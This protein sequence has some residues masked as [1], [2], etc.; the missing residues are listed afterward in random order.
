ML[1]SDKLAIVPAGTTCVHAW[2]MRRAREALSAQF[3]VEFEETSSFFKWVLQDPRFIGRVFDR[4]VREGYDITAADL[5]HEPGRGKCPYTKETNTWFLHDILSAP[6]REDDQS[7]VEQSRLFVPIEKAPQ[8]KGMNKWL[9][10]K[11][12]DKN[13]ALSSPLGTL[14]SMAPN[15]KSDRERLEHIA[16]KY[17]YLLGKIRALSTV[18][19]R[20]FIFGN[21]DL[22]PDTMRPYQEG[23]IE[24]AFRK[25]D[26]EKACAAIRRAFPQGQNVLVFVSSSRN[27]IEGLDCCHVQV[28]ED[29]PDFPS[30]IQNWEEIFRNLP[31]STDDREVNLSRNKAYLENLPVAQNVFMGAQLSFDSRFVKKRGT[32]LEIKAKGEGYIVWGPYTSLAVGRYQAVMEFEGPV[33][34]EACFDVVTNCGKERRMAT[35]VNAERFLHGNSI[36][37]RFGC[38]EGLTRDVETRLKVSGRFKGVLKQVAFERLPE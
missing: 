14:R 23:Y 9:K 12:K 18:E 15:L 28:V 11:T 30:S 10:R 25:E 7:E 35:V 20:I 3:G 21:P 6:S 37:I 13:A 16:A 22:G 27:I 32:S 29:K 19:K 4:Y 5:L 34:G 1:I 2:Q 31:D 33:E 36:A 26:V 24:W 8:R 38:A 17:T